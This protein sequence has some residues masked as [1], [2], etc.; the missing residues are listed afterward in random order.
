MAGNVLPILLLGGAAA[1]ALGKKRKKK[2]QA[3]PEPPD[4][5]PFPEPDEEEGEEG[6]PDEPSAPGETGLS[7]EES[8]APKPGKPVASGV[9]RYYT[10]AYAWKILFTH[11]GDYAAHY[12]PMG[13]LG[14]HQEVARRPSVEEA[15]KAFQF[16]ATN[17]DRRKRNLPPIL[18][19]KAIDTEPQ[20][21]GLSDLGE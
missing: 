10:G 1:V 19:A 5:L 11:D 21:T 6:Q 14:P 2:T 18:I 20:K 13:N 17:E 8:Q 9:E 16:W 12:Y 4:G 3:H 15:I 7:N